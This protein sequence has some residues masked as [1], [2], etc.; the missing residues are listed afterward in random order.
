MMHGADRVSLFESRQETLMLV[1]LWYVAQESR[2]VTD[3]PVFVKL[4]GQDLV[5]FR[6]AS[7]KVAC[8]S[9]ICMHRG[10][11]LSQG[12]VV[13]GTVECPFHG[14]RYAGDGRCTRI[15]A[16][17]DMKVPSR[18]RVDAYPVEERYGWVWVFLGDLPE[19][20]RPPI[21]ELPDVRQPGLALRA[22][23]LGIQDELG[24]GGRERPGRL[25]RAVRPRHRLWRS[26]PPG[27]DGLLD[28]HARVG[29]EGRDHHAPAQAAWRLGAENRRPPAGGHQAVFPH[30]RPDRRSAPGHQRRRWRSGSTTRIRRWTRTT[31]VPGG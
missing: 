16:H 9:D 14:W 29:R 1:N 17:P 18:A 25:A 30:V 21:P 2:N 31:P 20:E 23:R 27:G 24:A 4:L 19:A 8:V 26:R 5:L 12:K 28:R 10:A 7:G 3:K 22:R 13:D 15:P 6:D 11:S